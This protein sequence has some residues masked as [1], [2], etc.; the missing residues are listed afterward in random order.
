M[1]VKRQYRQKECIASHDLIGLTDDRI[2]LN[3]I[4]RKERKGTGP[5]RERG[6]GES[7]VI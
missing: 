6:K 2:L 4:E 7:A 1:K 3:G 5:M